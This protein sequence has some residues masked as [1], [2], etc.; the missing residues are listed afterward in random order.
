MPHPQDVNC[1]QAL[2]LMSRQLDG[3]LS[4]EETWQVHHHTSHCA[5]CQTQLEELAAIELELSAFEKSYHA[6]GVPPQF[7][8]KIMSAIGASQ[9]DDLPSW[10]QRLQEK[11]DVFMPVLR[12][13]FLPVSVG[14]MASF[15]IFFLF[16][17]FFSA[18]NAPSRFAVAETPAAP[19]LPSAGQWN[20]EHTIPPGQIA[21]ISVNEDDQNTSSF[22]MSSSQ[23]IK[24]LVRYNGKDQ[25]IQVNSPKKTLHAT[26]KAPK[27]TDAVMIRNEGQSPLKVNA[28]SH[29]PRA[30][31]FVSIQRN[32]LQRK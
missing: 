24:V 6:H 23:P 7:N 10:Q 9:K 25:D 16:S 8:T 13:P 22:R 31:R 15:L 21:V 14:V 2:L 4:K 27:I 11:F 28:Q 12:K 19:A 20:Q 18:Q 29:R 26:L 1:E 30:I 32:A 5:E 17:P 3:D